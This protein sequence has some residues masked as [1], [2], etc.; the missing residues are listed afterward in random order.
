MC[1]DV[2][3]FWSCTVLS[4]DGAGCVTA[5]PG[6]TNSIIENILLLVYRQCLLWIAV[7]LLPFA[8]RFQPKTGVCTYT[9][10]HA[11]LKE[12]KSAAAHHL[13][14]KTAAA[15]RTR[16]R[17]GTRP[18]SDP[19]VGSSYSSYRRLADEGTSA[20]VDADSLFDPASASILER[21]HRLYLVAVYPIRA[22][23]GSQNRLLA[24]VYVAL[25]PTL[26]LLALVHVALTPT[27]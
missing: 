26:T 2:F 8:G 9:R 7:L 27:L 3:G 21:L 17:Q 11:L 14:A 18:A 6:V 13:G 12:A 20:D 25:T 1:E 15:E 23:K 10:S 22:G 24:L 5:G 4:D 16:T 19:E